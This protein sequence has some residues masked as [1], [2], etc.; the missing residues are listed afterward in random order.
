MSRYFCDVLNALPSTYYGLESEVEYGAAC[1]RKNREN[2]LI[3]KNTE[4]VTDEIEN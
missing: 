4:F 1:N 3:I 2:Y